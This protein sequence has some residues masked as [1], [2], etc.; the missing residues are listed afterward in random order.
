MSGPDHL[1]VQEQEYYNAL[2]NVT[3]YQ[4]TDGILTFNDNSENVILSLKETAPIF[5]SWLLASDTDVTINFNA[6]DSLGGQ[7]PVNIYCGSYMISGNTLSIG[8]DIFST[9][10]GRN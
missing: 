5:G 2:N 8:D 7:A 1:M 10:D 4:I 6:D 9:M 3:G